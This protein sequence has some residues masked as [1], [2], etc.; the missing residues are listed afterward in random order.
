M[1]LREWLTQDELD[2]AA[3]APQ[4]PE[5]RPQDIWGPTGSGALGQRIF[6]KNRKRYLEL[7]HKWLV[8]L[9]VRKP[10]PTSFDS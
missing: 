10:E 5:I 8:E 3:D 1:P 7:R 2:A 9:G 6:E 4:Y